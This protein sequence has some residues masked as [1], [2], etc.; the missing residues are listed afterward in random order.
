MA[1]QKMT[2]A[3]A[4]LAA[5]EA[6]G[7]HTI[8]GIPGGHSLAIYDAL[9]RCDTIRH[10]LG[11]H[12]QG[13]G[14][15]ADGYARASGR[16]GVVTTV[17]GPAVANIACAMG[18]ASTD[19]SPVLTIASTVRSDLVGKARGGLHDCG[20]AI[21]MM[22]QVCRYVHRCTAVEEIPSA[23]TDL[24]GKLTTQ[25]PGGAFCEIPQDVLGAEAEVEI[26][27]PSPPGRLAADPGQV[28]QAVELLAGAER[29]ILWAGTGV[30]LSGAGEELLALAEKL[31]AIVICT[32]LGR[33]I[34]PGDHPNYVFKDGVSLT[35]VDDVIADAD[36][37]LAVGTMFK[38][39]DTSAWQTRL[40]RKLIHIDIDPEELGRSY[41]PDV[42]ITADAKAALQAILAAL[43]AR[44]PAA[45]E[46]RARGRQAEGARLAARRKQH[47]TEMQ[48]VDIF[49]TAMPRDG[50]AVFDRCSL[51]YW[52]FR[53]MPFYEPRTFQY[54]MGYGGLGGALPQAIGAKLAC[55]D[56]TVVCV[57]GDGGFQFTATELIV[58]VQENLPITILLCNNNAYGAI[59]AGQDRNFGGRRFGSDLLNP[60]FGKLAA[61]YGIPCQRVE[62]PEALEQTLTPALQSGNLNMI[63]CTVDLADPP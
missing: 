1:K 16:V 37:V 26:P 58:A 24:I 35:E 17:S 15:M 53:C 30:T 31:G 39:E 14:F 25:R 44:E 41:D 42:G 51:G 56:K 48:V 21:D 54:P 32:V 59:R 23:V 47:P 13:L 49:R 2:G 33:G 20:E 61:A 63:E 40:G 18:Q 46:W 34:I 19:T 36:L 3:E 5:I 43:P 62:T 28:R 27:E 50:I 57:I 6:N 10:V 22:R 52:A 9:S 60:D 38:Q 45:P 8:F 7:V 12:E 55:P 4:A 11:R 29:P